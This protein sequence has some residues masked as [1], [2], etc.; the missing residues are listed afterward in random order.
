MRWLILL[1]VV[2]VTWVVVL[3]NPSLFP[4]DSSLSFVAGGLMVFVM[5]TEFIGVSGGRLA[6]VFALLALLTL[7]L[8]IIRMGRDVTLHVGV[9]L[10]MLWLGLHWKATR[11][12]SQTA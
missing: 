11:T 5:A 6:R 10:T 3:M 2:A 9:G 1:A 7:G 12:R 8:Y 4:F